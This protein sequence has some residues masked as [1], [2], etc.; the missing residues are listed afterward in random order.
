MR[1][2]T[3]AVHHLPGRPVK[4]EVGLGHRRSA[5]AGPRVDVEVRLSQTCRGQMHIN[6]GYPRAALGIVRNYVDT[7]AEFDAARSTNASPGQTTFRQ[8]QQRMQ[9]SAARP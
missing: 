3:G 1:N 5:E 7:F 9:R 4:P 8:A 2:A 6:T